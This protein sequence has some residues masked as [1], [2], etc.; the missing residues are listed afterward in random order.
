MSRRDRDEW[1]DGPDEDPRP[2]EWNVWGDVDGSYINA[3]IRA[4]S[5]ELAEQEFRELYEELGCTVEDVV[6]VLSEYQ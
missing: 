4:T 1:G 5:A 3:Y 2:V 6:G